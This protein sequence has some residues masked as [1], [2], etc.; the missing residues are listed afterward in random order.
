[1]KL[2]TFHLIIL[3]F[4][5]N[6]SDCFSQIKLYG[7]T[8]GGGIYGAGVIFEFDILSNSYKKVFDFDGDSLGGYP[9][10]SLIQASNGLLYGMTPFGGPFGDG[11][12]F[13]FNPF[14]HTYI[15]VFDF[16]KE[17]TG[18]MPSGSL[19]QHI[20]GNIYGTTHAGYNFGGSIFEFNPET[21]LF[22]VKHYFDFPEGYIPDYDY[23]ISGIEDN[24]YN[25]TSNGG[26]EGR[27]GVL[28]EYNPT[29]NAVK[30]LLDFELNSDMGHSPIGGLLYHS[31]GKFYGSVSYVVALNNGVFF[32]YNPIDSTYKKLVDFDG[33]TYGYLPGNGVIEASNGKIYGVTTRGG[34][35][36]QG[37]LFEYD[38]INETFINKHNFTV[39]FSPKG[40]LVQASNDLIYGMT[41]MGGDGAG[42][43][44][45]EF[46]PEN[47]TIIVKHHFNLD[48]NGFRPEYTSLVEVNEQ[49][50]LYDHIINQCQIHPNP[51]TDKTI[52]LFA[53]PN[54]CNYTLY[55]WNLTGK[56]CRIV[57]D[58]TTREYLLE[59][60]DL[61][62]GLYIIELRGPM[63]FKGKLI[64]E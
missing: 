23:F 15:K 59:K 32:E 3:I 61:H 27:S 37:I 47:D 64:V 1:M 14:D 18:G 26:G 39:G 44:I 50:S 45:F 25:L 58:I 56:V 60:G 28:Y 12:V 5:T 24:L 34:N 9:V 62:S 43:I 6:N 22:T 36:D 31:N 35:V 42:G 41:S 52:I 8:S 40:K 10:G 46:N 19:F 17:T 2:L 16:E 38:P 30:K 20:N 63:I 33:E 48:T 29:Y 49:L 7:M 13:E 57:N 53:N 54:H 55:L 11:V 4:L 51:F 21:K